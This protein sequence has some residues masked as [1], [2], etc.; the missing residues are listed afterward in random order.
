MKTSQQTR[1][2]KHRV[3][4][5]PLW[6]LALLAI[7]VACLLPMPA[8]APRMAHIDKL[9]HALTFALLAGAG[10]RVWGDARCVVV[11]L[12]TYGVVIE[13]LQSLT[14]YRSAEALDLLAD[15]LG[16]FV[17]VWLARRRWG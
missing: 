5:R 15:A 2:D 7:L 9:E 10:C 11:A 14:P 1:I 4:G 13:L 8:S 17:G 3:W 6:L 12:L 16:L